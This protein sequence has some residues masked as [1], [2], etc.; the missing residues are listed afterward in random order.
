MISK[1][2]IPPPFLYIVSLII[3]TLSVVINFNQF[4]IRLI[5]ILKEILEWTN[6]ESSAICGKALAH[7]V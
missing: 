4:H 3:T 5:H 7:S 6:K 2:R 1:I